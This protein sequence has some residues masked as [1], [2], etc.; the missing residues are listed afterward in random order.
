M[1]NFM[2]SHMRTKR[3]SAQTARFTYAGF[4]SPVSVRML[5]LQ[6]E[7]R[8]NGN[9][10]HTQNRYPSPLKRS[11]F[12]GR[13]L[14]LFWRLIRRLHASAQLGPWAN[15]CSNSGSREICVTLLG[16]WSSFATEQKG[17]QPCSEHQHLSHVAPFWALQPATQI[18]NAPL[19][20][21]ALAPLSRK[22]Q[23]AAPV[24]V[25]SLVAQQARSAMTWAFAPTKNSIQLRPRPAFSVEAGFFYAK[26]PVSAGA[27]GT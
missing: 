12:P 16:L 17:D 1:R 10:L 22:P 7:F 11:A 27:K 21:Q 5:A 24:R 26:I 8:S 6:G 19:W 25:R 4:R 9:S 20:A 23:A 14:F 2:L 13:P 15:A 3:K 18:L